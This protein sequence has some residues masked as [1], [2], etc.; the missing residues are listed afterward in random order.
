MHLA[1]GDWAVLHAAGHDEQL[2]GVQLDSSIT[3]LYAQF[4]CGDEEQLVGVVVGVP[5]E[6]ALNL[7]ELYLVVV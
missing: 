1:V 5:D 3:H 6:L 4:A 7:D 2:P